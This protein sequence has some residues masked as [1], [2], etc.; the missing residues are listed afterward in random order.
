MI[1]PAPDTAKT[2]QNTNIKQL[3]IYDLF[4][5]PISAVVTWSVYP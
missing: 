5:S 4:K 2:V 1:G 3:P